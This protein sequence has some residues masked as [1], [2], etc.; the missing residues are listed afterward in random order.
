MPGM[1]VR[2]I[3]QKIYQLVMLV[4]PPPTLSAGYSKLFTNSSFTL[5]APLWLPPFTPPPPL[6]VEMLRVGEEG[7]HL[8]NASEGSSL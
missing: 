4:M 5:L 1:V 7:G 2:V 6:L 3:T 8:K